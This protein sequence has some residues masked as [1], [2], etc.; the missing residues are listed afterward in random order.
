LWLASPH[1][2]P[3]YGGAQ[4]RYRKYIP[5][6]VARGL[7]V[8]L[9]T[10]TPLLDERHEIDSQLG[11]YEAQPGQ[12]LPTS[13]L[14]GVPLER[15]RLP[16]GKGRQRTSIYYR[17]LQEVCTREAP[18]AVVAQLL[19]NLR[20]EARPWIEKLKGLG[21]ATLYSV[22]Q[23]P[24]WPAKPHKRWFRGP[25]YRRV[26]N[27]FDALVTN[28]PAIKDFLREIGVTTRVEYI[29]NGVNLERF[30]PADTPQLEQARQRMR[31]RLGI[32]PG[33]KVIATVGAVMPRKGPDLAIEAWS[34]LLESHPDT[35]LLLVGPRADRHDDKLAAFGAKI[36]ALV[37]NCAKPHQVHFAGQVD[38][39]ENWLRA[40]DLFVLPT[41]REGTPNSLLE[42]M[43][44][45]LPTVVTEF[46]GRS[47]AIGMPGS[48]YQLV[49]RS[50]QA[51]AGVLQELLADDEACVRWRAAGLDYIRSRMDVQVSLDTYADL[52]RELGQE[53]LA[54]R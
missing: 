18:S 27:S 34:S 44:T 7:D 23:F 30:R 45:G 31:D 54:R 2:Y 40:A 49:E 26:Y 28:S 51:I 46:T 14:D 32:A 42:A 17:A 19:T 3:T 41:N 52:Y 8:H 21:V 37:R 38:D 15:I 1:F 9:L 13:E 53:A 22:S 47:S 20:P 24:S 10:A 25:G 36:D 4:N 6:L 35:H 5:G 11:W 43:A 48:E 16:D 50:A 29:P 33:H 12:Y 39:V